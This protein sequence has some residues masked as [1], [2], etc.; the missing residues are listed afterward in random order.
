VTAT[1]NRWIAAFNH[2][3]AWKRQ[4]RHG[5]YEIQVPNFDRW[6][7]VRLNALR[8]MG[9]D[10]RKMLSRHVMPG[11]TVL[12]I[13]A[14][15]GLYSLLLAELVGNGGKV[16]A[17]EPDPVLFETA[18]TNIKQNGRA[19][20]IRLQKV[21][22]GSQGGHA[23]LYRSTFNSG[24]NRLSASPARRDAVP[25]RIARL[26][27]ILRDVKIDFVKMDVQGWEA[28]VLRGME[29]ILKSNPGVTLYFEYWPEGLRKAGEQLPAPIEILRQHGF[30]VSLPDRGEPLSAREIE[31]LERTYSRNRFINLLAKR[32]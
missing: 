29:H 3:P 32:A 5:N 10:E 26:D 6:L 11:M 1:V 30:A 12:D 25:V 31:D 8:L 20:T 7:Y 19:D 9:N 27:D 24:D 16:F 4:V 22:L 17:F 23:T 28:E 15:I 21:A 2:L 13:G 14:N 18:L